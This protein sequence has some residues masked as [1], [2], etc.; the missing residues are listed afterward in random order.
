M[1]S[2]IVVDHKSCCNNLQ[3]TFKYEP[4]ALWRSQRISVQVEGQ[5]CAERIFSK[6]AILWFCQSIS[7]TKL[8]Y[9]HSFLHSITCLVVTNDM[10]LV[11]I[12]YAKYVP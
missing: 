7:S 3:S 9:L 12:A 11:E 5:I 1:C 4:D 6:G 8:N 10:R 2:Q